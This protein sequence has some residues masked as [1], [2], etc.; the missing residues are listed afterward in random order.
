MAHKTQSDKDTPNDQPVD[1]E[2][3]HAKACEQGLLSYTD[4]K[5]G[6]LVMTRLAHLKRAKCCG[7]KCRHCPYGHKNVPRTKP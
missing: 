5:T 1:I 2:E 3:L 7:N 4:P 6:Y